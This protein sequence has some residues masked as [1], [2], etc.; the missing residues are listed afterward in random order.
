ML[1]CVHWQ[2]AGGSGRGFSTGTSRRRFYHEVAGVR[3]G[4]MN[5]ERYAVKMQPCPLEARMRPVR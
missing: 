3:G 5:S 2:W 4:D 1:N